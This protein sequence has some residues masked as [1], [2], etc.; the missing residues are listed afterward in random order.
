M[1]SAVD[2]LKH[3]D[4][5]NRNRIEIFF[6]WLFILFGE[7][8]CS[9]SFISLPRDSAWI[10]NSG[11]FHSTLGFFETSDLRILPEKINSFRDSLTNLLEMWSSGPSGILPFQVLFIILLFFFPFK[12]T[13]WL[14]DDWLLILNCMLTAASLPDIR[15]CWKSPEIR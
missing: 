15:C 9:Q 6:S 8:S 5:P 12:H 7:N 3:P 11:T 14:I 2:S 1:S 13:W 10:V 4:I